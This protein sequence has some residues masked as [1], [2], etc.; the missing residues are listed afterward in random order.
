MIPELFKHANYASFVRQLNMYGFHK[1]VG[2]SDNSMRASERKNKSPSE[3]KN[4]YFKQGKA[5]WMWLIQKPKS[6]QGK[7][8]SGKGKHEEANEDDEVY[9]MDNGGL[10]G[11]N[12]DERASSVKGPKTP[13][14]IIQG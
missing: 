13:L 6:A 5:N 1:Q 14:L 7:S 12:T 11:P 3:Y 9:E 4:P 10:A 2:L 8:K